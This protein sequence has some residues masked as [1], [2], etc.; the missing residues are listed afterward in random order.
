M[1][2]IT[3]LTSSTEQSLTQQERSAR[4][5]WVSVDAR[6][7]SAVQLYEDLRSIATY[8]PARLSV[9]QFIKLAEMSNDSFYG[10]LELLE[11]HGLIK[12]SIAGGAKEIT[13]LPMATPATRR[14]ST[15]FRGDDPS[16]RRGGIW[17]LRVPGPSG[18][19]P[20]QPGH[21]PSEEVSRFHA[22][23]ARG[24]AILDEVTEADARSRL[25]GVAPSSRSWMS[26]DLYRMM[27][28][29]EWERRPFHLQDL[30]RMVSVFADTRTVR[31]RRMQTLL[32]DL[33]KAG[34]IHRDY[35]R[36]C[37][38]LLPPSLIDG[39]PIGSDSPERS[40]AIGK[41]LD[42]ELIK[43]GLGS[44]P[45]TIIDRY[46]RACAATGASIGDIWSDWKVARHLDACG[47]IGTREWAR[48][49]VDTYVLRRHTAGIREWFRWDPDHLMTLIPMF[50]HWNDLVEETLREP[51]LS[52]NI[53]S[54]LW[55]TELLDPSTAID[56]LG[57][58]EP[59]PTRTCLH[60]PNQIPRRGEVE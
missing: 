27:L 16:G 37:I 25:R 51:A 42:E 38:A 58:E 33:S 14:R 28:T 60:K 48:I 36:R 7:K 46:K 12:T 2:V 30:A 52:P 47:L 3:Y 44:L 23:T 56:D 54:G 11:H 21:L 35:Q 22:W 57:L 19:A 49:L 15:T 59:K 41:A 31:D 26:L 24:F 10:R 34:L 17:P 4:S 32:S 55:T 45:L 50:R 43:R 29:Y 53:D 40:T 20:V 5:T 9:V 8:D 18:S 6:M 1:P 13:V 39:Y